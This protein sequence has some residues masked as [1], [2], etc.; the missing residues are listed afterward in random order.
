MNISVSKYT[1]NCSAGYITTDNI[2]INILF[3]YSV[4]ITAAKYATS[5]RR[6]SSLSCSSYSHCCIAIHFSSDII[7]STKNSVPLSQTAAEYATLNSSFINI[8]IC[9]SRFRNSTGIFR[10]VISSFLG[11]NRTKGAAAIDTSVYRSGSNIVTLFLYANIYCY[12]ACYNSRFTIATTEHIGHRS[13]L[14][15]HFHLTCNDM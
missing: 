6:C 14:Y 15:I 5:N 4:N 12:I 11:I 1:S 7:G 13:A 10:N 9:L 2:N 3:G 8:D